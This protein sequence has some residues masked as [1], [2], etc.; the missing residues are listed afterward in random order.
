MTYLSDPNDFC[1]SRAMLAFIACKSPNFSGLKQ[2][3][4][5]TSFPRL[6]FRVYVRFS[7][8]WWLLYWVSF[9]LADLPPST[10]VTRLSRKWKKVE[11]LMEW[12]LWAGSGSGTC[13]VYSYS[14][15]QNAKTWP[16]LTPRNDWN[17]SELRAKEREETGLFIFRMLLFVSQSA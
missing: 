12:V 15:G 1:V 10:H 16:H 8:K 13:Y 5:F 9:H 3:M 7:S 14:V 4:F 11:N 17:F 2:H 6:M